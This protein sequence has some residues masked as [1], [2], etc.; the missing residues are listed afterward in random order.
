ME[1]KLIQVAAATPKLKIGDVKYNTV[2]D[3]IVQQISD[4]LDCL[5]AALYNDKY[6][7][8]EGGPG[9]P[10]NQIASPRPMV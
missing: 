1:N 3:F 5:R 10:S 7:Y 8:K 4:L 6:H 2:A 9:D